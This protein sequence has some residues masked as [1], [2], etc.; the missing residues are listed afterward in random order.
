MGKYTAAEMDD[1]YMPI[2]EYEAEQK[3]V[4][5]ALAFCKGQPEYMGK[6]SGA[7]QEALYGLKD[8]AKALHLLRER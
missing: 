3:V 4:D 2:V 5:A 8:A 6:R 7:M 1:Y